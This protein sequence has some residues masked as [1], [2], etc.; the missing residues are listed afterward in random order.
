MSKTA[1]LTYAL[2]ATGTAQGQA[3]LLDPTF[4][5]SGYVLQDIAAA[6]FETVSAVVVQPDGR[7]V[8]VGHTSDP[9]SSHA[10]V[11]RLMDDGSL[12]GSFADAGVWLS[13]QLWLG[14]FND[15]LV[16][17]GGAIT[18]F[19]GSGYGD[20]YIVRFTEDGSLDPA[21]GSGGELTMDLGPDA[22]CSEVMKTPDNG[23]V[24]AGAQDSVGFLLKL[25]VDCAMDP[26]FGTGGIS[27]SPT[28][29]RSV[30]RSLT[31]DA[32]GNYL[33]AGA[34]T[35]PDETEDMLVARFAADGTPDAL[36]GENGAVVTPFA[37]HNTAINDIVAYEDG[38]VL[39]VGT[40]SQQVPDQPSRSAV[41]HL[42]NDGSLDA[43]FGTGGKRLLE[44]PGYSVG[45]TRVFRRWDGML[46]VVGSAMLGVEAMF[47]TW[48]TRLDQNG[49]TDTSFGTAG[50]TFYDYDQAENGSGL[51][52]DITM[53]HQ[54][55]VV[56]AATA[57]GDFGFNVLVARF[58]KDP[59]TGLDGPI[60]TDAAFS[61]FPV[62]FT[63]HLGVRLPSAW[64][65]NVTWE[66]RDI[67]GARLC[68]SGNTAVGGDV[69]IDLPLPSTLSSGAYFLRME[70]GGHEQ[71][72]R[73]VR[74]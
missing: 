5:G 6:M 15:V 67:L 13:P 74:E 28:S 10:F 36:F 55:R 8:V 7:M 43:S 37:D 51:D 27:F 47:Y 1:L 73:I 60:A 38:R 57:L 34:Q 45:A 62:P 65:G 4:G 53:D 41:V 16:G 32:E 26:S 9:F 68:G 35:H 42:M 66:L 33:A 58:R 69:A 31:K 22:A 19:G 11:M 21:F 24:L 46:I 29:D 48:T 30:F 17:P 61:A 20:L 72:I 25:T 52:P 3:D 70:N 63:D 56:V 23:F 18:A 64:T 12:D 39:L 44:V 59:F 50:N 14:Y 2:L 49:M 71:T 40:A 54:G